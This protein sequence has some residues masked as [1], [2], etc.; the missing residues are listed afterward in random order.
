MTVGTWESP[1]MLVTNRM[2][3][4][5]LKARKCDVSFD[6]FV[7]SHAPYNWRQKLPEAIAYVLGAK[8]PVPGKGRNTSRA[9][10][11]A[12][13]CGSRDHRRSDAG[14]WLAVTLSWADDRALL[15]L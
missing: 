13:R 6:E 12:S 15:G 8:R 1:A 9:F 11:C 7:G 3:Y 4:S 2:F 14:G 10:L 5:V